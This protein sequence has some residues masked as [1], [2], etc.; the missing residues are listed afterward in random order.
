MAADTDKKTGVYRFAD[1]VLDPGQRAVRRGNKTIE[2]TGKSFDVLGA[3]V[4]AAPDSLSHDELMD[5]VWRNAVVSQSTVAKRIEL[6]RQALGDDSASPKYI[7]LVRGHGYRL[8]PEVTESE[9]NATAKRRFVLLGVNVAAVAIIAALAWLASRPAP[10]PPEQSIAVLPFVSLSDD[11]GDQ[12]F[13]DG[14]TDE[15]SHV[16]ASDAKLQVTGRRSAFQFRGHDEDA[17]TIGKSLGV[18][19]LLEGSV[20]RHGDKLRVTAQLTDTENAFSLWSASYDR[21]MADIISIQQVIARNVAASLQATFGGAGRMAPLD[22]SVIDPETY[23]TYLQ[24]VSLSPYGKLHELGEAQRLIEIVTER[25]PGFASGWNRLAAI[26]G[27]RLFGRDPGYGLTFEE[28]FTTMNEAVARAVSINPDSAESYANLGGIA[29]VLESDAAKAAPLIERAV[30][31]DPND[32]DIIAFAA[33]F[34]KF[35]GRLDEALNLEELLVLRD[36]LCNWCRFRLAKSYMFA[37][38]A[39]DAA[40]EFETLRSLYGEHNWNYGV[41]LLMLGRAE[42]ALASFEAI[43]DFQHL[44]LQGRAAALCDLDRLD[45]AAPVLADLESKHGETSPQEVAQ[46]FAYCGHSVKAFELLQSSLPAWTVH[47]QSEHL[48]PL[49]E[50][51]R[52][53]PRWLD[54]LRQVGRAPEQVEAIPFS[55][56]IARTRLEN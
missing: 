8:I 21:E 22:P 15:L 9:R 33:E 32:L 55:L 2:L 51:L 38:R 13:A 50:P 56:E 10:E 43:K 14:L 25:A 20:R 5:A 41:T 27:R 24:A 7:G 42:D 54:L 17:Q 26:H 39:E 19:H 1:L 30:R 6:V 11:P 47:L 52:S 53:D 23:A 12:L 31:L 40:R 4:R 34:A 16:L 45:E 46:A 18:A 37:G 29:W 49:Y 28:S 44:R 48:S 35:I 3:L 36:P